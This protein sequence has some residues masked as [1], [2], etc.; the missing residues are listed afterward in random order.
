MASSDQNPLSERLRRSFVQDVNWPVDAASLAALTDIGL[1]DQ[2]IGGYFGVAADEV[3][4]L[5]RRYGLP[6]AGRK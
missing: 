3:M 5:R 6:S 2:E 1:S 4:E